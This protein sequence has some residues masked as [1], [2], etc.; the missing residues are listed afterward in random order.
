M[1]VIDMP[2]EVRLI[3]DEMFPKSMLPS[4]CFGSVFC[5]ARSSMQVD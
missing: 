5:D 1:D 3:R 4:R 2:I